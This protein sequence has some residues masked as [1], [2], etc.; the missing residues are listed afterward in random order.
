MKK[1]FLVTGPCIFLVIYDVVIFLSAHIEVTGP[2][3]FLVIYDMLQI[4][5]YKNE[6]Q[7]PVYF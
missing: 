7:D 6:L 1:L 2:C 4:T 3:I 5:A